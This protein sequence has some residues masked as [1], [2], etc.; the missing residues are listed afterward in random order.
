MTELAD[1]RISDLGTL[2]ELYGEPVAMAVKCEFDRLDEHH[3]F[4]IR[5]SPF[6]CLAGAGS[7]GQP[8]VSPKGDAPGF[9][10]VL[11]DRTLLLPDR[12][13]NNK[14]ET[15][16]HLLE[17]PKVALVFLVPGIREVLRVWGTAEIRRDPE[18]LDRVRGRGQRPRAALLIHVT[19]VYFHCGKALIRSRLWDPASQANA[20][21]FPPFGC[22]IRDQAKVA[23]SVEALQADMDWRYKE[24]LY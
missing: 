1:D 17:N 6:L 16:E 22:V 21:K 23:D 20:A 19:K 8:S 7:D 3:R 13:G 14:V 5:H 12:I 9:V 24:L 15:F 10:E 4:F 11:D 2:H 18:L